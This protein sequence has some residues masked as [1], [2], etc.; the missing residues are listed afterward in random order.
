MMS[1]DPA[2]LLDGKKMENDRKLRISRAK[3]IKRNQKPSSFSS[4]SSSSTT[5][6]K[7]RRPPPKS[8]PPGYVPKVDAKSQSTLGRATKLL[9]RAGASQL[10]K[11]VLVFEGLRATAGAESGV[12]QGGSGKKKDGKRARTARSTAWKK[13]Q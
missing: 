2:L 12:R 7:A 10:K 13:K 9:G 8:A 6:P 1:V 4:G 11:Q 3:S 5:A